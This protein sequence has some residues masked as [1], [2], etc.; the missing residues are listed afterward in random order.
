LKANREKHRSRPSGSSGTAEGA[1]VAG[2]QRG[3]TGRPARRGILPTRRGGTL[4][5]S[6]PFGSARRRCPTR[7][8]GQA[9]R[10]DAGSPAPR[11]TGFR[12]WCAAINPVDAASRTWGGTAETKDRRSR[13]L[14]E[15]MSGL[16]VGVMSRLSLAFACSRHNL[17]SN[18]RG[19]AGSVAHG[20]WFRENTR[21]CPGSGA[22]RS[23]MGS[24]PTDCRRGK[25]GWNRRACRARVY[26]SPELGH[27]W[28]THAEATGGVRPRIPFPRLAA[29]NMEYVSV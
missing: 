12:E 8:P 25:A 24:P 26:V 18:G 22:E 6:N 5:A 10:F 17:L 20:A 9:L 4:P 14:T 2:E 11:T 16:L 29:F 28:I 7:L 3:G 21:A 19:E 27:P 15:I 23:R 1:G 13:C